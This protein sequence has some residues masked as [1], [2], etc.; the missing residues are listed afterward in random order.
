[1]RS[2]TTPSLLA[3]ICGL[4]FFNACSAL[5]TKSDRFPATHPEKLTETRPIC[6]ECHQDQ[7][8][9]VLKPY[10]AFD[11]TPLFIK[12]HRFTAGRDG[13]LCSLCHAASFCTD[14]HANRNEVKPS[15]KLGDRPDRE[16]PHRGD[17]MTRHRID[18]KIDPVSCYRCHGR[19][20]NE[21]CVICHRQR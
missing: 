15:T 11:H 6:S 12:E 3:L 13:Q 9:A 2:I 18:G 7:L 10:A 1:M 21:K 17:F 19:A 8:K 5:N 20:N 4:L 14:C 16:L